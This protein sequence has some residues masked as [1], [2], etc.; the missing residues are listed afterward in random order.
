MDGVLNINKPQ[1]ITSH[2]VV[3]QTRRILRERRIGHTGTL[4][5]MAVGV[6]VLCIGKATRI[7]RYIE[8]GEKEYQATMMLGVVTD[9]QDSTGRVLETRQYVPPSRE[10]IEDILKGFVGE[11]IQQPPVYSALKVSGI[12]SYRL[13]RQGKA[14]PLEPRK[15]VVTSIELKEYNDPFVSISVRCS[16]GVYIRT[17]C[18]DIGDSLGTG[19]HMTALV[20]TRSGRFRLEDAVTLDLLSRLAAEGRLDQAL[21]SMDEALSDMPLLQVT[22]KDAERLCCGNP[23]QLADAGKD[24]CTV[25][26]H[27]PAG[28]LVCLA[29]VSAGVVKPETVF[30]SQLNKMLYNRP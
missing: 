4:D 18:A 22:E 3:E 29:R 5:P 30:C 6:L 14:R 16:K 20:R 2:D 27:D 7:A 28:R 13:A 24:G 25:R 10:T 21:I 19:A 15:V 11:V 23:V 1:G 9:T 8:A 12:P 26:V 17:L